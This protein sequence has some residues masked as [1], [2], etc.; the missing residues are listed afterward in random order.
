MTCSTQRP[1]SP[2]LQRTPLHP[3]HLQHGA[4]M[5]AFA[6]HRMP[7]NYS[8]GII[9]EHLHT[10]RCAGLFDVSHMG[11]IVVRGDPAATASALE[12]L[13]PSDLLSLAAGRQKYALL[14]NP[15]GGIIDD[16]MV[17]NLGDRFLLVVNAAGRRRDLEHLSRHLSSQPAACQAECLQDRALLALQGPD[18]AAVLAGLGD[19]SGA[20]GD[21]QFMQ[22]R[23]LTIAGTDCIVSRSGYTGEDGFELSMPGADAPR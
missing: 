14:T 15:Q 3:L 6:G 2:P 18:A 13:M 20:F 23:E 5:V 7:L 12:G 17:Q 1:A 16:L 19:H 22:V 4:R 9:E 10:R 11:Q 8:G 21:F